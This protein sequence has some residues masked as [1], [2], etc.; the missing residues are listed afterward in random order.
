MEGDYFTSSC[1]SDTKKTKLPSPLKQE[2]ILLLVK[3]YT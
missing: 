1:K 3:T 2:I